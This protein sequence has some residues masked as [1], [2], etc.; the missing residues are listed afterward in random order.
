MGSMIGGMA[1]TS[2]LAALLGVDATVFTHW[3]MGGM[4]SR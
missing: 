1:L 4:M 2:W 3:D